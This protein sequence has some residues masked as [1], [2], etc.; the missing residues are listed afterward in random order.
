MAF[1]KQCLFQIQP[2]FV[3]NSDSKLSSPCFQDFNPTRVR[4]KRTPCSRR[5]A[6][7]PGFNPTRV[8]LKRGD[9]G[10]RPDANRFRDR[11]VDRRDGANPRLRPPN[12]SVEPS[13]VQAHR[14]VRTIGGCHLRGR[15]GRC[16]RR[17]AV[18]PRPPPRR[19]RRRCRP[20]P[21]RRTASRR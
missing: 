1:P 11:S 19:T 21:R 8:R 13:R 2:G 10:D 14:V 5:N 17:G 12:G 18:R 15:G 9:R 20:S 6:I 3:S 4:L 16:R 7:A